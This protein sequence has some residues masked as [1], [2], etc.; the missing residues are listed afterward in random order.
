MSDVLLWLAL[1]V[2]VLGLLGGVALAVNAGRR[3]TNPDDWAA[4][5]AG[6]TVAACGIAVAIILAV[7]GLLIRWLGWAALM[8]A[9]VG[10]GE[11]RA[12]E[13]CEL[14]AFGCG[15]HEMHPQYQ[16][17]QNRRGES[18]CSGQDCRAIR[19]RQDMTG[20]WWI[21]IPEFRGTDRD[22]WI[23][24]P[25]E[26]EG[27]PDRYHDGHSH[28]CTADPANWLRYSTGQPLPVYCFSPSGAKS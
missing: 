3:N 9:L 22:P 16:G 8:F 4:V 13:A 7:I 15:H 18:C 20:A 12:E 14:G 5:L 2:L 28:A 19:A 21:Y 1:V 11:A 24:V 27:P 17:W 6:A 25:A 23:P 26:A 10:L